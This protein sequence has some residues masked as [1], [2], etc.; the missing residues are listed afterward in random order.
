MPGEGWAGGNVRVSGGEVAWRRTGGPGPPLVLAHGLTDNGLCWRRFAAAMA[1]AFDVVML[2]ARGHGASTLTAGTGDPGQDIAEAIEALGLVAPVVMGH[3]VGGRAAAGYAAAYPDRVAKL[4]LE[5]PAFLPLP[6]PTAAEARRERF[7]RQVARFQS[8]TRAEIL[9]MGR[10]DNPGWHDD[11]FPDWADAK[12]QVQPD[13]LPA[14]VRPWQDEVRRISAPCLIVHGEAARGS[15][16]TPA[17]AAEAR[18]LN[19]SLKTVEIPG[20]GHNTRRENFEGVVAA[21]RGFLLGPL[22][23]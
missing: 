15:L 5:D 12:L 20:A 9:A 21:V 23:G 8:M 14:Y 7:R 16:V 17:I 19:P 6:D 3:S 10:A 4:V 2:D 11:D 13:A 1:D 18:A 22:R